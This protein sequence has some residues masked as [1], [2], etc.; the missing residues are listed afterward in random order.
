M[1]TAAVPPDLMALPPVGLD[2]LVA[3]GG[4]MTRVD[5]K[6]PLRAAD[7]DLLVGL[8]PAGTRVL[9]IERRRRFG[10]TSTYL[11][12][13]GL[14]TYHLAAHR[15]RRRFK[16]RVRRYDATGATYLEVK[17]RDGGRTAKHRL[18]GDHL[19]AG[20]LDAE[21]SDFVAATLE[22]AGI[23]SGPV[24]GLTPSAEI[25]YD[26]TTLL[27][28]GDGTPARVTLDRALRWCRPD[29]S[30]LSLPDLVV[31]ETKTPGRPS[32]LDRLLWS[33]GH[34]PRRVSKYATGLAALDPH[35]PA[36]RWARTLRDHF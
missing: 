26:R 2:E 27:V 10:Y 8:A 31:V 30:R 20:R 21:G 33:L 24:P 34:R 3:A 25:R 7:A 11:D 4:L 5:R 29:G 32:S 16:V 18:A 15:R 22:A 19:G 6:Y 13:T 17:T 36:N 12:T 35:L 1:T 28:D 23:D 9:D 14:A